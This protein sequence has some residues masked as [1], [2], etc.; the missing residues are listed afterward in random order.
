MCCVCVYRYVQETALGH[1]LLASTRVNDFLTFLRFIDAITS[2]GANLYPDE[3]EAKRL[4]SPEAQDRAR[5]MSPTA[6][7]AGRGPLLVHKSVCVCMPMLCLSIT[8][9]VTARVSQHPHVSG[10]KKCAYTLRSDSI[11]SLLLHLLLFGLICRHPW[12]FVFIESLRIAC[13]YQTQRHILCFLPAHLATLEVMFS[14]T[15]LHTCST[16][17][18]CAC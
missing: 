13:G 6:R 9:T 7:I 11:K 14:L 4:M 16:D 8:S 1:E 2:A 15:S 10:G 12:L 3:I 5:V 17:S 18:V